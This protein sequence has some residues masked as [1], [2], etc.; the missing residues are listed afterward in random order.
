MKIVRILWHDAKTWSNAWIE[1]DDIEKRLTLPECDSTGKVIKEDE[2]SIF[3]AQS[4]PGDD[5]EYRNIIGIPKGAITKI[6]EL[7]NG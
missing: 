3:L 1:G 7:Y 5:K 4:G 6:E 2:A